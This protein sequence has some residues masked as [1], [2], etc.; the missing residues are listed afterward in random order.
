MRVRN[1]VGERRDLLLADQTF[2]L[3]MFYKHLTDQS[4]S[5]VDM[6]RCLHMSSDGERVS[7][8]FW[9]SFSEVQ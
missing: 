5:F 6:I 1:R 9:E 8:S 2:V 3:R 7:F 4:A